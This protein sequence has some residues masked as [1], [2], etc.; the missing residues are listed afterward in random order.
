MKRIL[1]KSI[2]SI[3]LCATL[4]GT[5]CLNAFAYQADMVKKENLLGDGQSTCYGRL[6]VW[7]VGVFGG[8]DE[9]SLAKGSAE[10]SISHR[11]TALDYMEVEYWFEQSSMPNASYNPHHKPPRVTDPTKTS[12]GTFTDT[13]TSYRCDSFH[14]RHTVSYKVSSNTYTKWEDLTVEEGVFYP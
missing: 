14:A 4:L 12:T 8:T 9:S 3:A 6:Y 10:T 13:I 5:M 1:K 11:S 7:N 2:G